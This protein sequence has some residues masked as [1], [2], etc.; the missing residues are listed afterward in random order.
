MLRVPCICPNCGEE[1]NFS[2]LDRKVVFELF[3]CNTCDILFRYPSDTVGGLKQFYQDSYHQSGLTTDLPSDGALHEYCARN[4]RGTEKD[5]FDVI[6][7]FNILGAGEGSRVLDFGANWGYFAF[8]LK[9]AGYD[10]EAYEISQK[11]AAY[12]KKIGVDIITDFDEVSDGFDVVF[13]S[14]VIEHVPNPQSILNLCFTKLRPGGVMIT[15]TPNGSAA[16]FEAKRAE[17]HRLWG[18]VHPVLLTDRFFLRL[19]GTNPCLIVTDDGQ[20]EASC[21]DWNG[22]TQSIGILTGTALMAVIRRP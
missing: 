5:F 6:R 2:R 8:Q 13:S 17:F 7:Y 21:A 9:T 14:H 20:F 4:F 16:C 15:F 1:S 19:A 12:G 11:R 3:R 10:V 22:K 18:M